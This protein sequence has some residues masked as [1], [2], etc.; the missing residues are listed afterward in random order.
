MLDFKM[1]VG[2]AQKIEKLQ[3]SF[4]WS[5]GIE[6]RKLHVVDWVTVCKSKKNGDLGIRR[7]M[8]K[9]EG[10][11][12]KW[13]WRFGFEVFPLWRKF[14][15]AKYRI[16]EK[17]MLWDWQCPIAAFFF[18]KVVANLFKPESRSTKIIKKEITVVVGIGSKVRLWHG[19]M[20]ETVPLK[21]AFLIVYALASDKNG[22]ILDF[23]EWHGM[24]WV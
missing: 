18:V 14:I 21:K 3:Y 23:G 2:V 4:L 5:D 8:D 16:D 20:V 24:K 1:P 12:A 10:T 15:C 11:L 7:L 19:I 9:N 22:F 6:K 13:V 17:K